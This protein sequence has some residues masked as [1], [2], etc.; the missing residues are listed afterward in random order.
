[1]YAIWDLWRRWD[2]SAAGVTVR[3]PELWTAFCLASLAMWL[4]L[5]AWRAL[6]TSLT[7]RPMPGPASAKLY[8]DSQMARYMPGKVGLPVVRIAGAADVG[9]EP[10]IMGAALFAELLSWCGVGSVV[11]GL[12]IGI[13]GLE[14]GVT[15]LLS[16]GVLAVAGACAL[17]VLSLLVVDRRR[18]PAKVRGLFGEGE[19]PVMP[20]SLPGWHLL[21]FIA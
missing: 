16:G 15:P 11:G 4:Q 6:I 17:G 1:V 21:H 5:S 13:F 8:L 19:G 18:F 2:E 10:R 7:N 9:V 20:I 14:S 12:A 3:L